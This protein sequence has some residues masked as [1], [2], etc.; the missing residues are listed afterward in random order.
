[1][2]FEYHPLKQRSPEWFAI[3][4]GRV[5]ASRLPDWLATSKAKGKEGTPLK[6]RLDY[7]R[8]L[9]FERKFGVNFNNYVSDAMLDGQDYEDFVRKQYSLIKGVEAHECGIFFSDSFAA[10]PDGL[11]G[12]DGILEI[13]VLRDNTFTEVLLAGV[14]ENH[15][16]QIQGQL[17]ASGRKWADYAAF[18]LN[19]RK[20]SIWRVTENKG[21]QEDI[22]ESLGVELQVEEVSTSEIYSI[23]G[24]LPSRDS[25]G[26]DTTP[27]N[28]TGGTNSW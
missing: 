4:R 11:I 9:W 15:F 7:E 24:E 17:L 1:M 14:P 6:A 3:R 19:T 10:S 8:E 27:T 18:N 16:L 5:T 25:V 13:K 23:K 26:L 2:N 22:I 12:K 28:N 20:I 21:T